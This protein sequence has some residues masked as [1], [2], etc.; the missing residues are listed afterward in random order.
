[1]ECLKEEAG[2]GLKKGDFHPELWPS[3][4]PFS[5]KYRKPSGVGL[6]AEVVLTRSMSCEVVAITQI[7]SVHADKPVWTWNDTHD[8]R[9]LQMEEVEHGEED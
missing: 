9:Q 4:Q 5:S 1:M 2:G 6:E 3:H 7:D 8:K